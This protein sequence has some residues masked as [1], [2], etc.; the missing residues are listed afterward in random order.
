MRVAAVGRVSILVIKWL[1]RLFIASR[2]GRAQSRNLR[3][4]HVIANAKGGT[5]YTNNL[6]LL[7]GNCNQTKDVRGM[8]L[9]ACGIVMESK[10]ID[11]L[12]KETK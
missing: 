4:D 5:V 2:G 11:G 10:G 8:E 7:C 6:Q 12:R 3:V 9:L 1:S